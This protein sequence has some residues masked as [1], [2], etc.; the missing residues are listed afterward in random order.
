MKS[1]PNTGAPWGQDGAARVP[2]WPTI[3]LHI[4]VQW[5]EFVMGL[6]SCFQTGCLGP[7]EMDHGENLLC[8]KTHGDVRLADHGKP[9]FNSYDSV[10]VG[11]GGG[12]WR[13]GSSSGAAGVHTPVPPNKHTEGAYFRLSLL[14]GP[15]QNDYPIIH[16]LLLATLWATVLVNRI[17]KRC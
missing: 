7:Q 14:Q 5:L 10:C 6:S 4:P 9:L 11:R 3:S 8:V 1:V 16:T 15:F 13:C 17:L 2:R 12:I